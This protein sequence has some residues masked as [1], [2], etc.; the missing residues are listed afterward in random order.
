MKI[1]EILKTEDYQN[2]YLHKEGLFWR[3]YE[4]SAYVFVKNVKKYNVKKKFVKKVDNDI[5]FIGFPDS[6]LAN[7]LNLCKHN[8][9]TI[10]KRLLLSRFF[11]IINNC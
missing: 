10:N 9:F 4:Y 1:E 2:I 8:G 5:V 7:I 3:S 11:F 6:T